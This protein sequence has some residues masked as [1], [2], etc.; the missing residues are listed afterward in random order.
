MNQ[1]QKLFIQCLFS[2]FIFTTFLFSQNV[3]LITQKINVE[4]AIRDKVNVT[5]NKLLQ[6]SQYVIIVN[7]RM[8]LKAFSLSDGDEEGL[9][10]SI[11]EALAAGLPVISTR[12]SGIPEVVSHGENGYLVDEGDTPAMASS[13]A[14]LAT[15]DRQWPDF[16]RNGRK[17]LEAEFAMPITQ[18]KLRSLL[19]EAARK[20]F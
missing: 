20:P 12:H 14:E 2:L 18:H 6:Q 1:I 8:D 19:S 11:T 10:V 9:P 13:M 5:I 16:G 7:A 17:R 15:T 3:E 4:N